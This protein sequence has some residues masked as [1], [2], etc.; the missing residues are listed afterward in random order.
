[1]SGPLGGTLE[2]MVGRLEATGWSSAREIYFPLI[3]VRPLEIAILFLLLLLFFFPLG[4][5]HNG[6]CA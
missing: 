2:F 1:M 5:L 4:F 3:F 6:E